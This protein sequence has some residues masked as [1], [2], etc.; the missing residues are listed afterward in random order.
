MGTQGLNGQ[1]QPP[2]TDM[3]ELKRNDDLAEVAQ[4]WADQCYPTENGKSKAHDK[5][6]EPAGQYNHVGQ[7]MAFGASSGPISNPGFAGSIQR[8]YD[9]VSDW[10]AVNVGGFSKKRSSKRQRYWTLHSGC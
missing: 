1:G 3:Y 5:K 8:W 4:R 2:A 10:P 9:E 6:R 7:N